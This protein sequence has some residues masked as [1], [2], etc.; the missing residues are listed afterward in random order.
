[1]PEILHDF[2]IR[3]TPEKVFDAI[4]T[5]NQLDN[6]WSLESAGEPVVG[7]EY[8]LYFGEPWDWRAR[9]TRCQPHRSFE[10]EMTKAMDDWVGTRVGFEL[11]AV[12]GGTKVRFHHRGWAE[13]GE[14][15][16]ISSYCW[17]TLLRLMKVYVETGAVLA[18][19]ERSLL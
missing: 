1:M 3:S 15:F 14:H 19:A 10:W 18:H 4:S 17:G 13:A 6:W 16:R 2:F 12:Q 11:E 7:E 8:R 5:P 9:V